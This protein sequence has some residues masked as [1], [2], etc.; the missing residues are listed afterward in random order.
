MPEQ[1]E[2]IPGSSPNT[3][4]SLESTRNGAAC[5]ES[6]FVEGNNLESE[7]NWI[8]FAM[9]FDRGHGSE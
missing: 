3:A 1:P 5:A 7:E 8:A 4:P 2:T 6:M 9:R